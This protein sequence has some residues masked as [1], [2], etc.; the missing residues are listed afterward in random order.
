[1]LNCTSIS[2]TV[3]G[4]AVEGKLIY[5]LTDGS[6]A[7][8]PTGGVATNAM[9]TTRL[10][11]GTLNVW[12]SGDR[13]LI[14]GFVGT[15]E[16][17]STSSYG[18]QSTTQREE[19][20]V[21]GRSTDTL[22]VATGGRGYN[23]TTANTFNASDSF[24]LHVTAPIIERLK[25]IISVMAQQQDADRTTLA[26]AGTNITNLQ[27]G[28]YQYVLATGSAN[29]YAVATP[30]L[31]AY[32]AGNI[33][34]F[35]ANFTNTGSAT[36]NVNSLGAKT[37]KKNDGATNLGAN[38][39]V[40]GQVVEVVYEAVGDV[41]QMQSPT[42]TPASITYYDKTVYASGASS[43]AAG[44]SSTA[45]N[46]FDTHTYAI[47]SSDLAAAVGYEYEIAYSSNWVSGTMLF[48]VRLGSTDIATI[49]ITPASNGSG[50]L[51][52]FLMGTAAAGPSVAVR[53][54]ICVV[55]DQ[56]TSNKYGARYGTANVATNGGLTLQWSVQFSA[57]NAGN[58]ATLTMCR[59]R[60]I[61][62]SAFA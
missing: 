47:P 14:D 56:E 50:T 39:I 26:T 9:T 15:L 34:R 44:A 5:N 6:V 43:T 27:T 3:G 23:G 28:S 17:V 33:V 60:K 32:A 62:T 4:S 45:Q 19:V 1:L 21:I 40:N 22:T 8:I 30:A 53:G 57:S 10:L 2:A 24:Y 54:S 31:A 12:T 49:S 52:G 13:W 48:A 20:L 35:K 55:H 18:V 16:V 46:N 36:L 37:I 25:D 29:A 41:F 61:S 11:G 58:N 42:G 51:R 38:D 59:V 7:R